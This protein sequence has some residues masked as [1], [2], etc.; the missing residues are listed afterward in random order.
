MKRNTALLALVLLFC[1]CSDSA[2]PLRLN[3]M[4]AYAN[5]PENGL[6]RSRDVQGIRT[7]VRL[8]PPQ[9]EAL[10]DR[11]TNATDLDSAVKEQDRQLCFLVN[12]GPDGKHF[13][14]DVMYSGA[15]SKEEFL[16]Q[17][18][19]LNFNWEA[20]VSLRCGGRTYAP[21]L[22]SLEN[23]YSLTKDRNV[24]LVFVPE[25]SGDP[26]FYGSEQL[27]LVIA[28]EHLGTGIQ[29]FTFDRAALRKVPQ[30]TV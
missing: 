28:D 26:A 18:Y 4:L 17:A 27:E 21:V 8:I 7:T 10:R 16:Q 15:Q 25:T 29:H 19:D 3:E 11:V 20:M 5:A 12:L 22:S 6:V 24:M 2:K 9:L 13:N 23:T 30:P 1:R 14:G